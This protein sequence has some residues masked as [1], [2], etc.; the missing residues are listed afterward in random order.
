MD[1]KITD[2][3]V[4]HR[5]AKTDEARLRFELMQTRAENVCLKLDMDKLQ[6]AHDYLV[7]S[8]IEDARAQREREKELVELREK[9]ERGERVEAMLT[10]ELGPLLAVTMKVIAHLNQDIEKW[11]Q[12]TK[13]TV[14]HMPIDPHMAETLKMLEERLTNKIKVVEVDSIDALRN[15]F[16]GEES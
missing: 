14:P 5:A 10:D 9:A 4:M 8:Y 13:D 16:L 1:G 11:T 2:V 7:N 15:I 6:E 12:A 3:F